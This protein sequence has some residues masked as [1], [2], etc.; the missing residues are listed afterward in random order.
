[1]KA[2]LTS[3]L[4]PGPQ[5]TALCRHVS[6]YLAIGIL[7]DGF[8][9]SAVRNVQ[10]DRTAPLGQGFVDPVSG[11]SI[12]LPRLDSNSS[13]NSNGARSASETSCRWFQA[14]LRLDCGAQTDAAPGPW[15][16]A[17]PF[18]QSPRWRSSLTL[19]WRIRNEGATGAMIRVTKSPHAGPRTT[20][21]VYRKETEIH[22]GAAG[23][24]ASS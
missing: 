24:A 14:C 10:K 17:A 11:M 4:S 15:T 22:R 21:R 6:A 19:S 8:P 13:S 20:A 7:A 12:L 3:L 1:M 5:N 18:L 9:Q 2:C 23:H 16:P